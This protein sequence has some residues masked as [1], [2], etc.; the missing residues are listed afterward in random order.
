MN[1]WFIF[2]TLSIFTL[3]FSEIAQK[4]SLSQKVD[5]SAIT[6]NFYVWCWQ[7]TLG[8]ILAISTGNL[9][10]ITSPTQLAKLLILAVAYFLGGTFFYT[11]YKGNSSS[12]S[13]I[14]G[15]ISILVSTTL[16]TIFFQ[17]TMTI[18]KFAGI[19]LILSAIVLVNLNKSEKFNKY[20]LYAFLGGMCYGV[21]YTL[22]KSFA[23]NLHPFSYLMY[24]CYSIALVSVVTSFKL[25]ITETKK[26]QIP[27]FYPM[28]FS[29]L[30]GASFNSFTFFSYRYGG[31][32]GIA[33]AMNTSSIFLIIILEVLFLKDRTQLGKK[34][35]CALI[36][37]M[38]IV[39][40]YTIK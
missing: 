13:V 33:D 9:A 25:I 26:L 10:L 34:I 30:F 1:S 20:N 5:I 32:V 18:Q 37:F 16:G 21:A 39:I 27:N 40:F 19:L 14:L 24:M 6:N 36:A 38:G 31:Q 23:L 7:G 17:E 12:I 15:S 2:A 22:D 8:L 4:V 11:S 28:F 35:L 29:G 3:A